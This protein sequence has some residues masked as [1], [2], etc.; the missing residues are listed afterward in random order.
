MFYPVS[1]LHKM[2]DG[3]SRHPIWLN[4]T[5]YSPHE[6]KWPVQLSS[7][8]RL[9]K[10][11]KYRYRTV[12]LLLLLFPIYFY[13]TLPATRE[14]GL[15]SR[16][17]PIYINITGRLPHIP[18]YIW[19]VYLDYSPSEMDEF[20]GNI[21][22]WVTNSP[23]HNYALL[24]SVG[25]DAIMTSLLRNPPHVHD[26]IVSTYYG[27]NKPVMR[28]DFMRYLL[29]A[30]EGGVYS[31]IDTV[32]VRPVQQ[33]VPTEFRAQTRLIVGIEFDQ[34]EKGDWGILDEIQFCQWTIAAAAGHPV[35]WAMLDYITEQMNAMA[36]E[37]KQ[38]LNSLDFSQEEILKITGPT[39]WTNVVLRQIGINVGEIIDWRNIT[40]LQEPR[41]YGDILVMPI[42]AF[43][44]GQEH[45][46][47]D[48]SATSEDMLVKHQFH[49]SWKDNW[50]N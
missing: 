2:L 22:S 38:P 6:S 48:R 24:D 36:R 18:P 40:G 17:P 23:S 8:W 12:V 50:H 30:L 27:I 15:P 10:V 20:R 39:A 21:H 49:G 44:A 31:D 9:F 46:G 28:G 16:R 5:R 7:S 26:K 29:L 32:L 4:A 1:G 3:I 25:A 11:H 42:N 43:G 33:W 19:Q 41:L 45:S 37:R 14:R 35:L 13:S 34:R 47:S